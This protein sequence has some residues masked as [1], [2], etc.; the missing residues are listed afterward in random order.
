[1][2]EFNRLFPLQ[3]INQKQIQPREAKV[4]DLKVSLGKLSELE[5]TKVKH[6]LDR[7][8]AVRGQVSGRLSKLPPAGEKLEALHSGIY[9]S[10]TWLDTTEAKVAAGQWEAED[11]SAEAKMEELAVCLNVT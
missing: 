8:E 6:L 11:E 2:K 5:A 9:T 10:Q 4:K 1:M 3:E 7:W